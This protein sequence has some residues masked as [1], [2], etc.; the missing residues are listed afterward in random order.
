[1]VSPLPEASDFMGVDDAEEL[2]STKIIDY[3]G[4]VNAQIGACRIFLTVA[5]TDN[6]LDQ[7]AA[8]IDVLEAL[9]VR[10]TK[11]DSDYRT[12]ME[13]LRARHVKE[14]SKLSRKNQRLKEFSYKKKFLTSKL[15]LLINIATKK[16][17]TYNEEVEDVINVRGER[18][19]S[20]P[21][22]EEELEHDRLELQNNK[23]RSEGPEN[24]G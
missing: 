8:A 20:L 16:G 24:A 1:M 18:G 19:A 12:K 9:L 3:R 17:Y 21:L 13:A 11:I 5:D 6:Q 10:Q 4:Q 7:S 22:P 2:L 14:F 15:S 23:I